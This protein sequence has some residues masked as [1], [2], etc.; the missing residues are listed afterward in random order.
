MVV[1]LAKGDEIKAAVLLHPSFVTVDDIKGMRL[2]LMSSKNFIV[3]VVNLMLFF[4][5]FLEV[6]LLKEFEPFELLEK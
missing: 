2:L 1:Q 3:I 4:S 5:Y 6:K